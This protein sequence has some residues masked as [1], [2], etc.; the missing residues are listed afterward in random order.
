MGRELRQI[1]PD[2][3]YHAGSRGSNRFPIAWD[4]RDLESMSAEIGRAATRHG[5]RVL[6]WCVLP[7][8][9]HLIVQTPTGGFSEGFREMNGNH[10]RRT[11]RRHGR[12]AHLFK[13][14]PWALEL[15][16]MAHLIGAI[17][18]VLR[19]PVEA[20]LCE[21][22]EGWRF[23]SYRAVL[24]LEAAPPWLDMH[25]VLALFGHTTAEARAALSHLVHKGQLLVPVPVSDTD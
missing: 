14:R 18:Y 22:A 11:N 9:T 3:I 12:E 10:A 4:E 20:E 13:N 1:D 7:N 17:A 19:N 15:T 6:A 24:G 23:S 21:R 2:A 8:H 5:W 16:T 25:D